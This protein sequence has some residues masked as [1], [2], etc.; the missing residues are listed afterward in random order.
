MRPSLFFGSIPL[1]ALSITASGRRFN[2]VLGDFLLFSTG[3][4]GEVDVDLVF[5]FVTGEYH[6]VGIDDDDKIT[7][8]NVWGII[9]FVLTAQNGCDL[10]THATNGLI[11]TVYNIPVALYG[12]LVRMFGGEM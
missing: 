10:G 9:G 3:V 4:T 5:Q 7:A 2:Q 1:T 8:V 12:S 11:S 6:L